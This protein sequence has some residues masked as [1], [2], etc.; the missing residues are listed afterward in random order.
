MSILLIPSPQGGFSQTIGLNEAKAQF[1]IEDYQQ[2]VEQSNSIGRVARETVHTDEA[3]EVLRFNQITPTEAFAEFGDDAFEAIDIGGG[4]F[5]FDGDEAML[6]TFL[7]TSHYPGVR[8]ARAVFVDDDNGVIVLGTTVAFSERRHTV[9]FRDPLVNEVVAQVQADETHLNEG[10]TVG[11]TAP[12]DVDLVELAAIAHALRQRA[13][14][15]FID[16]VV[17]DRS[18]IEDAFLLEMAERIEAQIIAA[19]GT[20]GKPAS[21]DAVDDVFGAAKQ[22]AGR[23]RDVIEVGVVHL[24]KGLSDFLKNLDK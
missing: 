3:V 4:G 10:V 1:Y 16:V 7:A 8:G 20:I 13:S 12:V 23:A 15:S 21:K 11:V 2:D 5:M 18:D 6:A 22:A 24:R 9:N 19:G 14:P 17:R